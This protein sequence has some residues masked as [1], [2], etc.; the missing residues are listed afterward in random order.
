MDS[1]SNWNEIL[2]DENEI[3]VEEN[4]KIEK[5]SIEEEKIKILNKILNIL[6]LL[7]KNNI[8]FNTASTSSEK[9]V[10]EVELF[11]KN[12]IKEKE[13]YILHIEIFHILN[14]L[15]IPC[16]IYFDLNLNTIIEYITYKHCIS[17]NNLSGNIFSVD[18]K[19]QVKEQ[20]VAMCNKNYKNL[21]IFRSVIQNIECSQ[22][23]EK[24]N[25]KYNYSI[26]NLESFKNVKI[27]DKLKI[28]EE[29]YY[30]GF[31][32]FEM[33][34]NQ[35]LSKIPKSIKKMKDNPIIV[36]E[37]LLK[38]YEMIFPR[39]DPIGTFKGSLVFYRQNVK[40][41]KS[42]RQLERMGKVPDG[43]PSA[44]V[45]NIK[46]YAE[47]NSKDIEVTELSKDKNTMKFLHKNHI[48]KNCFY[49]KN[50]LSVNVCKKLELQYRETFIGYNY[51]GP[52]IEG[53]F[54]EKKY[55]IPFY[56]A[57]ENL[58]F[59]INKITLIKNSKRKYK[60]WNKL[61]KRTEK[62]LEIKKNI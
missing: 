2:H 37:S 35:R 29:K 51:T 14:N 10:N 16:R 1:D 24:M 42:E 25:N 50:R 39:R 13:L 6:F 45:K 31:Y 5:T 18:G 56:I 8:K 61:I 38:P 26:K 58:K 22:F 12:N 52:I 11:L 60:L 15:K 27:E 57:F 28:S 19:F 9:V 46:L 41:L 59:F 32:E 48:P 30:K 49:S 62:Y 44:I 55:L 7:N 36:C 17:K 43:K 40:V 20:T 21:K 47:W 33:L 4:V 54:I 3:F 53:V 34:D 23:K